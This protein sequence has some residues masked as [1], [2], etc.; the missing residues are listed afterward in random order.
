M[1]K[2]RRVSR[3]KGN[4]ALKNATESRKLFR[5]EPNLFSYVGRSSYNLCIAPR[6][7]TIP[8]MQNELCGLSLRETDLHNI[9][10]YT[11]AFLKLYHLPVRDP[12]ITIIDYWEF[13]YNENCNNFLAA[14]FL[15][16]HLIQFTVI[17]NI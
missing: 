14:L 16:W 8:G 5:V 6:L 11:I 17:E 15:N 12:K 1:E 7:W 3:Y 13:L 4:A 10:H 9:L 2:S